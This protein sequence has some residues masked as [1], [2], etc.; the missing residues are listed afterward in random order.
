M[1]LA[2]DCGREKHKDIDENENNTIKDSV[3]FVLHQS[4]EDMANSDIDDDEKP[5]NTHAFR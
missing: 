3:S 4:I 1:I 2:A 5:D